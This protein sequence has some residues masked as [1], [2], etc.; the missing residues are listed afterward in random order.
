MTKKCPM[1]GEEISAEAKKC[2]HCGEYFDAAGRPTSQKQR[3][4]YILLA[5]FL[6]GIGLHSAYIGKMKI[7]MCQA[8]MGVGGWMTTFI[9]VNG[10]KHDNFSIAMAHI[11]IV[12]LVSLCVWVLCEIIS[13]D[14]DAD[15]KLMK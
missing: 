10:G 12:L 6:G 8:A 1:C 9:I 11:S 13:V 14:K 15:G 3:S 7:A 5:I 4:T 2:K